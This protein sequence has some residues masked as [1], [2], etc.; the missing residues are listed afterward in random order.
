MSVVGRFVCFLKD[1]ATGRTSLITHVV[2]D[3]K[4]ETLCKRRGWVGDE[5]PICDEDVE[6]DP[7]CMLCHKALTKLRRGQ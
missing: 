5:G 4:D 6:W 7:C 2:L 1:G 3:G